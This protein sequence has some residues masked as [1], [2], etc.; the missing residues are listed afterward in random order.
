MGRQICE[1]LLSGSVVKKSLCQYRRH[2]RHGFNP[3]VKMIPWR[4]KWQPTP[5]FFPGKFHRGAWQATVQGA[6]K[7]SD[8]TERHTMHAYKW[9]VD[10]NIWFRFLRGQNR[11]WWQDMAPKETCKGL[12]VVENS[13][14]CQSDTILSSGWLN[15]APVVCA[16]LIQSW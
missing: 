4:R 5:I 2:R 14:G 10:H 6:T 9:I 1:W 15:S 16:S 8:M 11:E 12:G 3:C 7:E 13:V